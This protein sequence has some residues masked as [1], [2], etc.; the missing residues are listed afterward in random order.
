MVEAQ[1]DPMEPPKF[2]TN[3]KIPRG[4]PS[5]PAPVMHSPS[6]LETKSIMIAIYSQ[7]VIFKAVN[8]IID[9]GCFLFPCENSLR[10]GAIV[11][12]AQCWT[13][14]PFEGP[15]GPTQKSTPSESILH[16]DMTHEWHTNIHT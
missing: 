10:R 7:K 2:K 6:R 4:P 14:I 16:L 1:V 13:K 11:L 9:M 3:K 15:Q 12:K 5:P 8:D